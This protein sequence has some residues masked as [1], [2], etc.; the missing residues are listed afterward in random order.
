MSSSV[1]N[2]N[3]R[4]F[5][6]ILGQQNC[7]NWIFL[8]ILLIFKTLLVAYQLGNIPEIFKGIKANKVNMDNFE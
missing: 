5:W 2:C 6:L 8:T 7:F 1:K 3:S 4:L